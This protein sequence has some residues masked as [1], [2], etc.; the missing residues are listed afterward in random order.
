MTN[1]KR[2]ACTRNRPST[3]PG[4]PWH[5]LSTCREASTR[6]V[7]ALPGLATMSAQP[8]G[9]VVICLAGSGLRGTVTLLHRFIGSRQH[10]AVNS[11]SDPPP[12]GF[13]MSL[14]R[15]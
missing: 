11:A 15:Y 3:R 13:S 7:V 6:A 9:G 4:R 2:H 14:T 1:E 5:S 10:P 8:R 12:E